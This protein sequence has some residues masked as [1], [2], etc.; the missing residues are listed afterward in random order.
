MLLHN[1]IFPPAPPYMQQIN[2]LL[3]NCF[4]Q[5]KIN[6]LPDDG[7]VGPQICRSVINNMWRYQSI[8]QQYLKRCLIKDEINYMFRPNVA[9]LVLCRSVMFLTILMWIK[10]ELC[11]FVGWNCGNKPL[12][13]VWNAGN[14]RLAEDGLASQ[15]E[16]QFSEFL[17]Y[18]WFVHE[19]EEFQFV[20]NVLN[21]STQQKSH[22][23]S[24]LFMNIRT[25]FVMTIF[26]T[27]SRVS[28][29][30]QVGHL[31]PFCP[32]SAI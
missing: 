3:S 16:I 11:A 29:S 28:V 22:F 9:I 21:T 30:Q 20:V 13:F 5:R 2:I 27:Q 25:K 10:W 19:F 8:T 17:N 4:I 15:Q 32:Q 7:P 26:I 12:G 24:T 31:V 18:F 23:V 14:Y 1:S 6:V